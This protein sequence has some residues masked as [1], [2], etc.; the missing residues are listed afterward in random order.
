M[1]LDL[2]HTLVV[3][4]AA[5]GSALLAVA[6]I[7]WFAYAFAGVD[8]LG[9]EQRLYPTHDSIRG[10]L[11]RHD[12]LR[13]T[14]GRAVPVFAG[15]G[16]VTAI[17][18][19]VLARILR[20]A[21]TLLILAA[22]CTALALGFTLWTTWELHTTFA[23]IRSIL[24]PDTGLRSLRRG[25]AGEYELWRKLGVQELGVIASAL[26]LPA[27][28]V[29]AVRTSTR[30]GAPRARAS[31]TAAAWTLP[32]V[33]A[34]LVLT[35]LW[36]THGDFSPTGHEGWADLIRAARPAPLV[37][38]LLVAAIACFVP[39]GDPRPSLRHLLPA[40]LL[41]GLGAAAVGATAPHRRTIDTLYP[42]Q[43]PG[44]RPHLWQPL[45]APWVL[46]APVAPTCV[47][48]DH[49]RHGAT[50]RLDETGAAVLSIDGVFAGLD[51]EP[52]MTGLLA[53]LP[54][55]IPIRF[56]PPSPVMLLIDR[57]IPL[58]KLVPTLARLPS[59]TVSPLLIAGTITQPM[60]TA[61]GPAV[62]VILCVFG[63]LDFT[64]LVDPTLPADATWGTIT[65]DP[66]RIH[67]VTPRSIR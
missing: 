8:I 66:A 48:H 16:L 59:L 26:L 41:L 38:A 19:A 30:R 9:Y 22:V 32:L 50:I 65:D 61:E 51:D 20:L 6:A 4:L 3:T 2:R 42:L 43:D 21:R 12:A 39:R 18:A 23:D 31:L 36:H 37:A 62:A 47:E 28:A 44:A 5:F 13:T 67:P 49:P 15:L 34:A 54:A 57:R 55:R 56:D 27:L 58:A 29:A 45:L 25:D 60:P 7:D 40:A 10:Y 11:D 63:Q 52:A 17:G 24:D 53:A 35:A 46:D 14:A 64:D 1:R 33:V